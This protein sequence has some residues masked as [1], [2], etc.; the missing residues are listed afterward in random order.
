MGYDS[1][2]AMSGEWGGNY[3]ARLFSAVLQKAHQDYK[4]APPKMPAGVSKI[5]VCSISGKRP[6]SKCPE[7]VIVSDYCSKEFIPKETCDQLHEIIYICP[8]SGK[9]AGKYCP[10]P[11]PLYPFSPGSDD[12]NRPEVPTEKCDIHVNAPLIDL[13]SNKYNPSHG[14]EVYICTDPRNG[15]ELHRAIF[16]NPLQGGG[17]P[18]HYIQKIELPAGANITDCPLPDHQ[19]KSKKAR[20][21]I[22]DILQPQ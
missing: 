13:N 21:V 11:Q 6:S 14:G 15:G 5:S 17:C 3:P 1:E 18:D 8:D 2:H 4:V 10:N 7:Q 19:L 12:E 20:E 9:L 16:S 22:E